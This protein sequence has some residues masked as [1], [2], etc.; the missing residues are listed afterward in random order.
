MP[1]DGSSNQ[2]GSHDVSAASPIYSE[3]LYKDGN[4]ELLVL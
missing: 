2:Q 4:I 1:R 3:L